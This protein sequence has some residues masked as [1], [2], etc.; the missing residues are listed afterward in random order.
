MGRVVVQGNAFGSR[1]K[2]PR[3]FLRRGVSVT[4]FNTHGHGDGDDRGEDGDDRG[5][6]GNG[7][8]HPDAYYW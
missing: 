4:H 8:D 1:S 3:P 6:G 5:E 2:N 7:G